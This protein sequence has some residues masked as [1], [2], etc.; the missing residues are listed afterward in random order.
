MKSFWQKTISSIIIIGVFVSFV[1][2]P[3]F[4]KSVFAETKVSINSKGVSNIEDGKVK[5]SVLI[6]VIEPQNQKVNVILYKENQK[7]QEE[8]LT[9]IDDSIE[10]ETNSIET[11]FEYTINAKVNAGTTFG[12]SGNATAQYRTSSITIKINSDGT[13]DGEQTQN[14]TLSNEDP[15]Q[16]NGGSKTTGMPECDILKGS[17]WGG[18]IARGIYYILFTPTSFLFGLSAQLMDFS[19]A[20]TLNSDNYGKTNTGDSFVEKGWT[21]TRDLANMFFIIILIWIAVNIILGQTKDK[22]LLLTIVLVGLF[23]NFSLF[24]ARVIIDFSNILGKIFYD[25][26]GVKSDSVTSN[27]TT[28]K[29]I[30]QAIVSNFNPQRLFS[31]VERI[32]IKN[33]DGVET[34]SGDIGAIPFIII[35]IIMSIINLV[36]M[37]VFFVVAFILI[38]RVI[39]LWILMIFAPIAFI[40]YILPDKTSSVLNEFH[41]SKW[42][43]S[44]VQ[45][46]FV[47]P[48]F[49]FFLY[50]I[51]LFINTS[52][53]KGF[54]EFDNTTV[55]SILNVIVPLIILT[56]L[57]LR[58][59]STATKLSGEIGEAFAKAG[60]MVA[61]LALGG[62]GMMYGKALGGVA[63]VSRTTLGSAGKKLAESKMVSNLTNS[64]NFFARGTGNILKTIGDKT[65]NA[66][67][68]LRGIKQIKSLTSK[69]G[70]NLGNAQQGGFNQTIKDQQK[71][72]EDKARQV[73]TVYASEKES[74]ELRD[75][76]LKLEQKKNSQITL[77]G[78]TQSI[79]DFE[80]EWA[81]EKTKKEKELRELKNQGMEKGD[82]E[83]D[84]KVAEIAN[85]RKEQKRIKNQYSVELQDLRVKEKAVKDLENKRTKKYTER[86]ERKVIQ[87]DDKILTKVW[88]RIT[89]SGISNEARAKAAENIRKGLSQKEEKE[90]KE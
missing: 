47:V 74:R 80:K 69:Y 52:F 18:C 34:E 44:L 19:M 67:F 35:T 54:K 53:L 24:F 41:H 16:G 82:K 62:A 33:K 10:F 66:S 1:F 22:K 36:G 88:K 73:S 23:I 28:E 58:A 63:S 56:V 37:Y 42:W 11:G 40:S 75:A 6:N 31:Q 17:T 5:W 89:G 4:A 61:G 26:M 55:S 65:A 2:S 14:N 71:R 12:A 38:G 90:T 85:I 15:T 57:L 27:D 60:S 49:L 43:T 39:G 46:S 30:S 77:N 68:D 21:I 32:S 48:I 79:R 45:Q 84:D 7:I 20:Y 78:K 86:I 64:D 70:L 13:V 29:S 3:F 8:D 50:L 25:N 81:E 59:K 76:K 87:N 83:Y 51:L 72:I 9:L